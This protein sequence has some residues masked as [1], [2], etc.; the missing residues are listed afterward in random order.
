MELVSGLAV[1]KNVRKLLFILLLMSP[2]ISLA[3]SSPWCLVRDENIFCSFKTADDCYQA[4]ASRGGSC[5]ENYQLMGVT[6]NQRWCVVTAQYRR[7]RYSSKISC[8]RV[9]LNSNG[10]C[11]ENVER[12]LKEEKRGLGKDDPTLA[13][14]DG[15]ITCQ[16]G[17]QIKD[18]TLED[19][20][21]VGLDGQ[22][23]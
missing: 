7:C 16:I 18:R 10:G 22:G 17:A 8:V 15:D 21:R 9:A 2:A 11:V 13:C 1:I 23:F 20:E 3:A 14:E 6:G 4:A 19:E 12:A 5:R